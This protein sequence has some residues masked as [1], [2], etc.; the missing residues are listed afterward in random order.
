M[1]TLSET[2]LA[3]RESLID[4][5]V[6]LI[7]VR[8]QLQGQLDA[9]LLRQQKA[10]FERDQLRAEMKRLSL[11][12]RYTTACRMDF[13]PQAIA[14]YKT[15]VLKFLQSEAEKWTPGTETHTTLTTLIAAMGRV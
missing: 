1:S 13:A 3:Y 7:G 5:L 11:D 9:A 8:D 10:E 2:E 15:R 4:S 14:Q 6:E 12:L